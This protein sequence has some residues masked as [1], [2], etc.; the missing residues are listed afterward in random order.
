MIWYFVYYNGVYLAQYKRLQSC[1][2]FIARKRL[3]NDINND[4]HIVDSN[5][6]TYNI[7][8][9]VKKRHSY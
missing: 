7:Y 2:N 3:S 8:T 9:G 4:L 6:D 1:I 5:G